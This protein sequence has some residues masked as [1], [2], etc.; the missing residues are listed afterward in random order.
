MTIRH[1]AQRL[2]LTA[3]ADHAHQTAARPFTA[4]RSGGVA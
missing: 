2:V 3:D 1:G 4:R